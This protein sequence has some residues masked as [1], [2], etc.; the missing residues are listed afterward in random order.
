MGGHGASLLLGVSISRFF[1]NEDLLARQPEEVSDREIIR[2]GIDTVAGH[3]LDEFA[4]HD[5]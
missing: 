5:T 4:L 3:L 1:G 2:Q